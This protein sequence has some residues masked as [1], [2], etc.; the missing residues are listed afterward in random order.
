MGEEPCRGL[1]QPEGWGWSEASL[2]GDQGSREASREFYQGQHLPRQFGSTAVTL[3]CEGVCGVYLLRSRA[4]LGLVVALM[5][6]V[7]SDNEAIL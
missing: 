7:G 5:L 4:A 1:R 3:S 6:G 2:I